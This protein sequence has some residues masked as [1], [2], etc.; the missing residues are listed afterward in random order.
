MVVN[1]CDPATAMDLTAM[2]AV[3]MDFGGVLGTV[4]SP[5]CLKV[6][7]ATMVT[8]NGDF[9]LH[10]LRGGIEPTVDGASPFT[11]TDTGLSA[12]F[13]LPTVGTYG[14]FCAVHG[15]SG[16]KGAVVVVP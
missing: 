9:S 16:M 13:A 7:T 3:T 6:S 1:G 14:F 2:A 5:S 15:G 12:T 10:P 8:F 11:S 4:Y